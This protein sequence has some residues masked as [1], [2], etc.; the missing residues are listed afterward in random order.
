MLVAARESGARRRPAGADA[1]RDEAAR[2]ARRNAAGR[3]H[4][5]G[6]PHELPVAPS[7]QPDASAPRAAVAE[8]DVI[9]GLEVSDFWA[10]VNALR[11]QLHR[12]TRRVDEADREADHDHDRRPLH[13]RQLPGLPAPAGRRPGDCGR[14]R[15]HAAVAHRGGQAPDDRRSPARVPGTRRQAGGGEPRRRRAHARGGQLRVGREP[16]QHRRG[17][18]PRSGRRSRTKTGRSSRATTAATQAAG[19]AGCGTSTSRT[20]G[21]ATPAAAASA[22]ARRRRSAARSPTGGTAGC[23]S[24]SR[25]TAT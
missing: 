22:T 5:S 4:R 17:S 19:R 7:A 15:G 2:R 9:V 12:S 21:S 3:R 6:Q 25:P 24:P 20:S 8:A 11:D 16:G 13:P 10:T 1:E 14:R 18:A 23:R